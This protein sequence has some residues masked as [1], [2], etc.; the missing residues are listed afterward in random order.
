MRENFAKGTV[1]KIRS[2]SSLFSDVS[3]SHSLSRNRCA[4]LR[5]QNEKFRVDSA[6]RIN[7]IEDRDSEFYLDSGADT[8]IAYDKS[9]FNEIRPAGYIKQIEVATGTYA[10]VK[11]V[12]SIIIDLNINDKKIINTIIGVEYVPDIQYNL[13]STGLLC[14]KGCKTEHD[15]EIYTLTDKETGDIFMTGTMQNFNQENF[16]TVDRWATSRSKIRKSGKNIWMQWHRRLGHLNMKNVKKLAVMGLIDTKECNSHDSESTDLCESCTMGKM[17][18]ASNKGSVRA[19]SSR[20]VTR[21]NQRIHTDL[22]EEGKIVLTPR[23]KRYVIIFV[24]DYTDFTWIYLVR[25]K[26]EY[27]RVLKEFILMLKA[28]SIDIEALRCDNAGENINDE[29]DALLKEHGIKWEPTVPHNSHQNGVAERVFRTIFNRVRAC[30]YDAKLPKKLWGE[31]CHTIVYLKNLS[32]CAALK[33]KT[34]YEAWTNRKPDIKYLRSIGTV[35]YAMKEKAKKLNEHA[36]KCRLLGYGGFNQYV[37]WD[38]ARQ[39]IHKAVHVSF[40]EAMGASSSFEIQKDNDDDYDYATL[41]FSRSDIKNHTIDKATDSIDSTDSAERADVPQST[42]HEQTS[43]NAGNAENEVL[44]NGSDSES[45][46]DTI[47]D[48][49]GTIPD[50][51]TVPPSTATTPQISPSLRRSERKKNVFDEFFARINN[52]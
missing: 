3:F 45:H 9:L 7:R 52:S 4:K 47:P 50:Q 20:R 22:A 11:E 10:E 15:N 51:A 28:E 35:C 24:D 32:P 38:I 17:H 19:D 26:S 30:L 48:Q 12:G 21:K 36:I 49:E 44:G 27:K 2:T 42:N 18:R 1:K 37:L 29:T 8:H 43:D 33:N 40:D 34:S 16:Y 6:R 23:G 13:I 41:N 46:D 31:L 14:R 5:Q 25:K 39:C